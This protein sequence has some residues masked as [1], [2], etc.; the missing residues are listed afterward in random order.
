[1]RNKY[2]LRKEANR[3]STESDDFC[4]GS[5]L[6]TSSFSETTL[7]LTY[8]NNTKSALT[9]RCA[10]GTIQIDAQLL[11]NYNLHNYKDINN[12]IC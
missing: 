3:D 1:M 7:T 9:L 5:L 6:V 12:T 4:V 2:K 10:N 11:L 8:G